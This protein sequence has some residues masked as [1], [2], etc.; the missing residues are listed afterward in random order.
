MLRSNEH[1]Y[2]YND[3]YMYFS[4][5]GEHSSKYHL[6][7]QNSK[8]LT[9]ENTV[10]AASEYSNAILQEGTYYLGT[11]RKQK[12]FKRK[13]AAEALTKD[14]YRSM[15]K[16]LSVGTTGELVFDS[17]KYWGWTVVLDTVGDATFVDRGG[18]LT[19]EFEVTFKTIGTYLAHNVYPATWMT[20]SDTPC[21]DVAGTNQYGIPTVVIPSVR[22]FT[23]S[24]G[25]TG[26]C[27]EV[28]IQNISNNT[29]NFILEIVPKNDL[30]KSLYFKINYNETEDNEI[31]YIY[32]SCSAGKLHNITYNSQQSVLYLNNDLAENY[33]ECET[34]RQI[35]GLLKLPSNTP[36]ELF[37]TNITSNKNGSETVM[38]ITLDD[39]SANLFKSGKDY[40][41]YICVSKEI[42]RPSQYSTDPFGVDDY[43]NSYNTYLAFKEGFVPVTNYTKSTGA[44]YYTFEG[45][46][47]TLYNVASELNDNTY[48]VYCGYSHK[49]QVFLQ[50]STLTSYED[51][52]INATT[53]SYN[54]L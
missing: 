19:V 9:L 24:N 8:K 26:L 23:D 10:G 48:H 53:T 52:E 31:E 35:N 2:W 34:T 18:K 5:K 11:S 29:Q 12:T 50:E 4:F 30:T 17:D 25:L 16:W 46:C 39:E 43:V 7:I 22:E 41:N 47:I 1:Y 37:T 15:M 42:R 27:F 14:E 51:L 40:Y 49:M 20:G 32:A 33:T 21:L 6:F 28:Y 3:D 38:T 36:V 44:K 13:C 45:N 54:N